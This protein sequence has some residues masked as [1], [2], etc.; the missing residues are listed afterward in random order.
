[1]PWQ[2]PWQVRDKHTRQSLHGKEILLGKELGE[3]GRER[4]ERDEEREKREWQRQNRQG[5]VS[6]LREMAERVGEVCL[7]KGQG[8][9]PF[10]ARRGE[11]WGQVCSDY[12]ICLPWKPTGHSHCSLSVFIYL[13]LVNGPGTSLFL[14]AHGWAF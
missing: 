9:Y 3:K 5:S 6:L 11:K 12:N 2:I 8:I 14:V 13:M 4:E 7:L 10:Q 1:M